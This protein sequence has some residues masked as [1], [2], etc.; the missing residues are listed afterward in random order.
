MKLKKLM[1]LGLCSSVAMAMTIPAFAANANQTKI[2]ATYAEPVISVS[3]PTTGTAIINPYKLPYSLGQD[4]DGKDIT[5]AGQQV[6]TTP[7]ALVNSGETSLDVNVTVTGAVSGEMQL[8]DAAPE[9]S[10]TAKKAHMYLEF[11]TEDSLVGDV[12]DGSVDE[13]KLANAA[14]AW[15]SHEDKKVVVKADASTTED[16][17]ITLTGTDADGKVQNGGIAMY[18]LSGDVVKAPTTP[19]STSDKVN[20]TVA[21]TFE[22]HEEAASGGDGS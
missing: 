22:P 16:K 1:A 12:K 2:T 10:E 5:I 8:S 11:K 3:V 19:W 17:V 13:V 9:A 18:R 15:S 20:V 14:K 6:A 21:F 4:A 7:L